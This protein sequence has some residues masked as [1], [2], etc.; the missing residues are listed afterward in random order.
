MTIQERFENTEQNNSN[1]NV[2]T[3]AYQFLLP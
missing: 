2:Y 1:K 3:V